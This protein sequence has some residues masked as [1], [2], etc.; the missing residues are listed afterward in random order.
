MYVCAKLT[1]IARVVAPRKHNKQKKSHFHIHNIR[2]ELQLRA[3]SRYMSAIL[4][5]YSWVVI[6]LSK[7]ITFRFLT[8]IV[9]SIYI[10]FPLHPW[11]GI[12]RY[13]SY[14]I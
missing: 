6:L 1:K 3:V 8:A 9:S 5:T 10:Y 7:Y 13:L 14:G 11:L 4:V 2:N 12:S